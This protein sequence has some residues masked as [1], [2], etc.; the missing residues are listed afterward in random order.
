[1]KTLYIECNM[2]AA[3]DMLMA[4]LLELHSDPD[5]FIKKMNKLGI[6]GVTISKETSV[7]GGITGTHITVRI[8]NI[9]EKSQDI[10]TENMF[11][12]IHESEDQ[13]HSHNHGHHHQEEKNHYHSHIDLADINKIINALSV[14]DKVKADALAVY[15]LIAEAESEVHGK[16]VDMIHFH[17]VGMMDAV[18]DIVGVCLLMEELAPQKVIVSPVHVG[19]G[20]IK[21]AHGILPVPA[22][23]TAYI[24]KG[25]PTYGGQIK[26]ELCT[27]T[28][29]ALLKHFANEFGDMPIM[30]TDAIGYGMGKK[31]FPMANC[32][33]VFIG[34]SKQQD[35]DIVEIACNL[36]DMTGEELGFALEVL[37]ENGALDVYIVPIQMKKSRPGQM[38]ICLCK[39][40]DEEKMATLILKH[41]STFGVRSNNWRRYVLERNIE[42]VETE[43]GPVHIKT[44][45]GHGVTKSKMEYEDLA[46][47]ARENELSISDIRNVINQKIQKNKL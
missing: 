43:Y 26:G 41:T 32:V 29:A 5:A 39:P 38:L 31:E 47:I 45:I 22:P 25:V 30:I 42:T 14:S 44:G 9:E 34:Q 7:K 35:S 21:C 40:Q 27:P 11:Q 20:Q 24:L 15:H 3:G 8:G 10:S 18:A 2:G 1:M 37:M 12:H 46:K 23:A 33:R 36:D 13:M 6:P 17:E 19:S 4:A 16:P 28:G